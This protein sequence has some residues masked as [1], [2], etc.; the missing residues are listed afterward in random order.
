VAR[1]C[2]L[3][4]GGHVS[5]ASR[6][7]SIRPYGHAGCARKDSGNLL[8]LTAG[9]SEAINQ[10]LN[11]VRRTIKAFAAAVCPGVD[12]PVEV[13]NQS[14]EVGTEQGAQ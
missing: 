5:S 9:D 7:L 11:S 3:F 8:R 10:A 2:S 14:Y 12:V 1:W 6:P 4:Y 13:G